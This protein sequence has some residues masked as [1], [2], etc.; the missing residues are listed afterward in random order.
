MRSADY[1]QAA[2]MVGPA[3]GSMLNKATATSLMVDRSTGELKEGELSSI[4]QKF[5]R[6]FVIQSFRWL[7]TNEV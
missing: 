3:A 1:V 2:A 6:E 7:S 5:G 4:N